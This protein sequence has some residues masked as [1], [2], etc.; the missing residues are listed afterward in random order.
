YRRLEELKT[1]LVENDFEDNCSEKPARIR[2]WQEMARELDIWI[3]SM[4]RKELDT[5]RLERRWKYLKRYQGEDK[6]VVK[7]KISVRRDRLIRK[8]ISSFPRTYQLYR[9]LITAIDKEH[10]GSR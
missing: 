7:G 9:R 6:Y 10:Y 1:I 8:C 3:E 4:Q 5:V 2:N